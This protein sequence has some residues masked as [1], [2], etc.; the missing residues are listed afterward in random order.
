MA[1]EAWYERVKSWKRVPLSYL[2]ECRGNWEDATA[3]ACCK[4]CAELDGRPP[5]NLG[6]ICQ[7]THREVRKCIHAN[8][9][10]LTGAA[11]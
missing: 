6:V 1:T 9:S 11:I 5:L 8:T 4:R 7:A 2:F 3:C 10:T